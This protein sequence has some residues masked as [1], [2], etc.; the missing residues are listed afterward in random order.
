MRLTPANV[1]AEHA[2]IT[3]DAGRGLTLA[4]LGSVAGTYVNGEKVEGERAL[5]EGDRICLGPPGAKAS[6]KLLVVRAAPPADEPAILLDAADEGVTL[7]VSS[8]EPALILDHVD[9]AAPPPAAPPPPASVPASSPHQPPPAP[10]PE[11]APSAATKPAAGPAPP[12]RAKPEYTEDVPSIVTSMQ[13][14]PLPV[15]PAPPAVRPRPKPAAAPVLPRVAIAAG[16]AVVLV[17]GSYLGFR[18]FTKGPPVADAVLPP[19]VETGQTVTLSGSGFGDDAAGVTVRVGDAP[20]KIVSASDSQVAVQVPDVDPEGGTAELKVVVETRGGASNAL[21][22]TVTAV[23]RI[24]TFKPDVAMPGDD[25]VATGKH[26]KGK[27]LSVSVDGLEADVLEATGD[28]LRFRVPELT[29]IPG[30]GAGVVV[31]RGR[32]VSKPAQLYLGRLPLLIESTPARAT[33]GDRVTL[34]GRGF[35]PRPEGNLVRFGS[36]PAL[37]LQAKEDELVV[38]A[39][40]AGVITTQIDAPITI[41]TEKGRSNPLPFLITRLSAGQFVPHY[42]AAPA[43]E[44]QGSVLVATDLGPVLVLGGPGDAPSQIERAVRTAAA[45]NALVD[46]AQKKPVSLEVRSGAMAVVGGAV[47]AA[48]TPDDVAAYEALASVKGRRVTATTI[49]ALW[50]SLV[51]DQLDLFVRRQRPARLVQVTVR[52][53]A[54]MQLYSEALRRAGVG[55]GVPFSV[56]S[57][58]NASLARDLRDMALLAPAEGEASAAAVMQGRWHGTMWEEGSGEKP[59]VVRLHAEGPRLV[60]SLT[61]TSG[62]ISGDLPI[63]EASFVNGVLR[64]AVNVHGGRQQFEGRV[65]GEKVTGSITRGGTSGSVGRFTLTIAE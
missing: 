23:P 19:R 31:R 34:K 27:P 2:R 46:E 43:P 53:R 21:M 45:L 51:Q 22:L 62:G 35:T 33:A 9:S 37:V 52:G 54:M 57:P 18:S 55:G 30:R 64:F 7:D 10:R 58:L 3:N 48:V 1:S 29:V 4:D 25:V 8:A 17:G 59:I 39:P 42:F 49:A 13:R 65:E 11:P 32:E 24:A 56:V 63:Q 60:G 41:E 61:T 47:L 20:G 36:E 50:T 16:V 5:R 6:V 15:P 44:R 14:Q 40:A 28:R 26:L 12:K 38:S